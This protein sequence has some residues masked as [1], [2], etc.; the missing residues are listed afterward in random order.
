MITRRR[1]VAAIQ[2]GQTPTHRRFRHSGHSASCPSVP[3]AAGAVAERRA[4]G[5]YVRMTTPQVETARAADRA[6]LLDLLLRAFQ[7]GNPNHPTFDSLYPDLF[8][9][10]DEALGR[11]LIVR[12]EGRIVA[13]VG[14]YPVEL[15][16]GTCRLRV[17]G[18][19]QVA[20]ATGT[21]ASAG[22]RPATTS[23]CPSLRAVRVR[24]PMAGRLRRSAPTSPCRTS[25]G[26][27]A[28]RI[29]CG[30]C[31]TASPGIVAGSAARPKRGW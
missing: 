20:V 12:R 7:V 4:S 23:A 17:A 27:C 13:C 14:S 18:I 30:R 21:R 10:S 3:S 1:R 19:G 26:R 24:P 6:E 11:H 8:E 25:S 5:Y 2:T 15:V 28:R 16:I 22:R 29:L 9:P 31:A